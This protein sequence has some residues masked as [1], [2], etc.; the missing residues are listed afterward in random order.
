MRLLIGLIGVAVAFSGLVIAAEPRL[1]L[2]FI[3][4]HKKQL[5]LHCAAVAVRLLIGYLLIEYADSTDFPL[6][7]AAIGW[8]SIIAAIFLLI[9]GRGN[10]K[11][12]ISWAVDLN[13]NQGRLAGIFAA[14]FGAF[15]VYIIL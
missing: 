11:K 5:W 2:D 12:L 4:R 13:D 6:V 3:D 15:M 1:I 7:V 14:L 8:I 9:L 10:F